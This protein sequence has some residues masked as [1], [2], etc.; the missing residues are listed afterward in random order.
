MQ[1]VARSSVECSKNT[2]CVCLGDGAPGNPSPVKPLFTCSAPGLSP[3]LESRVTFS[4]WFWEA[5]ILSVFPRKAWIALLFQFIKYDGCLHTQ[6]RS[7]GAPPSCVLE[8]VAPVAR[9]PRV[10]GVLGELET[11]FYNVQ[12]WNHWIFLRQQFP[13]VLMATIA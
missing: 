1:P 7:T 5:D 6:P 9:S 3:S 13:A 8:A 2:E 12:V 10:I 11:V 4:Q